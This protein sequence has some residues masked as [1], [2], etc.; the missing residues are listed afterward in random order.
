MEVSGHF[1]MFEVVS[2]S[3]RG[4][5]SDFRMLYIVSIQGV[6]S[7]AS[8]EFQGKSMRFKTFQRILGDFQGSFTGLPGI[9]M[10]FNAFQS[11]SMRFRWIEAVDAI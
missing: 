9:L 6:C 1:R 8:A 11:D 3:F 5:G 4:L 2:K 10:L 7:D